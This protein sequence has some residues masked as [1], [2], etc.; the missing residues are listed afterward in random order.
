MD[1]PNKLGEEYADY[2]QHMDVS[3]EEGFQELMRLERLNWLPWIGADWKTAK[4]RILIVGESHYGDPEKVTGDV[5]FSREIVMETGLGNWYPSKFFGNFHRTLLG[6][7]NLSGEQRTAMWR[8][9]A[10]CNFIQR[11]MENQNVRPSMNEFFEGWGKFVD[12]L[13][14]L[15]PETVVFLGVTAAGCFDEAMSALRIT[16]EY[17]AGEYIAGA[18]PR[19][20]S[21]TYDG[22][23]TDMV[24]IRHPSQ[25]FS[26]EVWQ[27][28]L[29]REIP[30]AVE[31]IQGVVFGDAVQTR[32]ADESAFVP[33]GE[34]STTPEA[35]L[36]PRI[37]EGLPMHLAHKPV[38]AC[39]YQEEINAPLGTFDYDDP[40]FLS[41]GH[42]QWNPNELSVKIIREGASGRWSRQSEEVPVQRLPFMMEMLLAAICHVQHPEEKNASLMGETVV[43][44]QDMDLLNEQLHAWAVPLKAGLARVKELLGRIDIENL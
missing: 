28:Y 1:N 32:P 40:R 16:H 42:A 33:G 27:Q 29:E 11:P 15:R 8:H 3:Y 36:Q 21:M 41:I 12:L 20:F 44:P 38:I 17:R 26:W 10:F 9:L 4:H 13:K 19:R 6:T 30:V 5:N 25:Y 22:M 24:A 23:T 14:L 18:Y 37:P 43:A 7:D 34:S 39:D 35:E 31:Y 2:V